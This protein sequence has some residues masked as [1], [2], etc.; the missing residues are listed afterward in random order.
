VSLEIPP[1][2][3]NVMGKIAVAEQRGKLS[4]VVRS[5]VDQQDTRGTD[6]TVTVY[7][8]NKVREYSVKKHDTGNTGTVASTDGSPKIRR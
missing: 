5:A 3:A 6:T 4:L 8:G 1:E 7:A 2:Q